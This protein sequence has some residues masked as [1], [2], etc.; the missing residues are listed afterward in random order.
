M[1]FKPEKK[2][3]FL[4]AV[5]KIFDT[6]PKNVVYYDRNEHFQMNIYLIFVFRGVIHGK[7]I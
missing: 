2:E 7:C 4:A 5:E 3:T 1:E 6:L